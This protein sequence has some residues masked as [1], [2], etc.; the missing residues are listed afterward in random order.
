MNRM[1]MRKLFGVRSILLLG[2]LLPSCAP[3][4]PLPSEETSPQQTPTVSVGQQSEEPAALVAEWLAFVHAYDGDQSQVS[5]AVALVERLAFTGPGA[6]DPLIDVLADPESSPYA[7]VLTVQCVAP[8]MSY[9]YLGKLTPLAQQEND[10][11]TRACAVAL[12][13]QFN[14]ADVVP[15]LRESLDDSE[16]RVWFS[17]VL[18]LAHNGDTSSQQRRIEL[19]AAPETVA[20]EKVQIIESIL[21]NARVED[22]AVLA[23]ALADV[24]KMAPLHKGIAQALGRVGNAEALDSLRQAQESGDETLREIAQSAIAAI[25]ERMAEAASEDEPLTEGVE[26]TGL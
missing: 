21:G 15:I 12:I 3:V 26:D 1:M 8:Y 6:L 9:E 19:Y 25:E 13:G 5:A 18:G 22:V 17:A 24:A 2:M 7:K 20:T 16:R 4:E 11:T 14:H 10:V 23:M